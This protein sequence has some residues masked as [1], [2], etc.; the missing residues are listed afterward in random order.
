MLI[1]GT[2]CATS[3]CS[4]MTRCIARQMKC[5]GI[6]EFHFQM[7]FAEI[8]WHPRPPTLTLETRSSHGCAGRSTET[9]DVPSEPGRHS[10]ERA[11][12]LMVV[13]CL[14]SVKL[15]AVGNGRYLRDAAVGVASHPATRQ[16][17]RA[18]VARRPYKA[19]SDCLSAK[20]DSSPSTSYWC[21]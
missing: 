12:H 9:V 13:S 14:A 19:T 10:V 2:P 17:S 1:S 18:T 16:P 4:K 20:L 5:Q 15:A 7:P 3:T 6:N 8:H 21:L 11:L